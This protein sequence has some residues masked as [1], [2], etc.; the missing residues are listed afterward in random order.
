MSAAGIR[1]MGLVAQLP[2]VIC[3]LLGQPSPQVEV[4]HVATGSGVRSDFGVAPLCPE[5]HRGQSGFHGMGSRAFCSLY[6][7]PGE[8]EYGLLI[9]TAEQLEALLWGTGKQLAA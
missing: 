9:L 7:I 6:R 8:T 4:H 1:Y 3:V 2:C 5:H